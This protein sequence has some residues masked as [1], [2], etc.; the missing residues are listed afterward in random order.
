MRVSDRS[1]AS[2]NPTHRP[3]EG[4]D[5]EEPRTEAA[6]AARR[7]RGCWGRYATR[8]VR[9]RREAPDWAP[10]RRARREMRRVSRHTIGRLRGRRPAQHTAEY[11][12]DSCPRAY[13]AAA[14][15]RWGSR[16]REVARRVLVFERRAV[17]PARARVEAAH[18]R[19]RVELAEREVEDE[20]PVRE[21]GVVR[22]G[23]S[24]RSGQ[25]GRG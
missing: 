21:G 1:R 2:A 7:V 11:A 22:V 17:A 10:R 19:V 16:R 3:R 23:V 14:R 5:A 24:S 9:P 15:L 12:H 20:V 18:E 6:A 13:A 25:Q 8:L 4:C